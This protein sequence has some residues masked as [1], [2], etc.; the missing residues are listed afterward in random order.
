MISLSAVAVLAI[1]GFDYYS[2]PVEQRAFRADHGTMKASGSYSHGLGILGSAMITIGVITYSS[3]KRIR[4]LWKL[5]MLSRW[6]EFHITLCLLGP[7]LVIYHTTFKTGGI[8][9]ISLWCMVSVATSGIIGRYLYSLMPRNI[10]G[11]ELSDQQMQEE[12]DRMGEVLGASKHGGQLMA[13]MDGFY[14]S[15]TPPE[16]ITQTVLVLIKLQQSKG[17]IRRAI[18]RVAGTHGLSHVQSRQIRDA[19]WGRSSLMQKMT[20]LKQVE[21]LFHYW[22]VIH[23]PFSL[24]MFLTLGAHVVVTILLG[25][26]WIF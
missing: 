7:I 13:A 5:G 14:N 26:H 23:L 3:R 22:H 2:S 24:I 11:A 19:A 1:R 10:K 20:V 18:R 6:L 4:R 8:A 25:Y 9:A 12:L 21:R 16:S 15:I 17:Q